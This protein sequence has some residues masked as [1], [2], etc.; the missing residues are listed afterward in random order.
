MILRQLLSDNSSLQT[1]LRG[2]LPDLKN[3]CRSLF[4]AERNT[5][6]ALPDY[7]PRNHKDMYFPG[8]SS[9]SAIISTT[10][11]SLTKEHLEVSG[12]AVHVRLETFT[13]WQE[14]LTW[15]PPLPL[16]AFAIQKQWRLS[17]LHRP[18]HLR[19]YIENY[20][21]PN[22]GFTALPTPFLPDLQALLRDEHGLSDIHIHLNGTTEVDHVWL[23]SLEN[24]FDYYQHQRNVFKSE[25]LALALA[26][27]QFQQLEPGLTP[28]MVYD[29][30]RLAGWL[31]HK[32]VGFLF[33]GDSLGKMELL[34]KLDLAA[35]PFSCREY[36]VIGK[37]PMHTVLG[38][39]GTSFNSM[40][41]ETIFYIAAFQELTCRKDPDSI[42]ASMFHCYLLLL[43]FFNKLVVQQATQCGFDQFQKIAVNGARSAS[44][45][46][47]ERRFRQIMGNSQNHLSFI[48]GRFSPKNSVAANRRLLSTIIDGFNS[49]KKSTAVEKESSNSIGLELRLVA[50]FIKQ[51]DKDGATEYKVRH[52]ELRLDLERRANALLV[53]RDSDHNIRKYVTGIDAA[54]NEMDTSPEVF[55]PLY[56]LLRRRGFRHFT[57]HAGEDYIH[58]VSGIRYLYEAI[59]FLDLRRGDRVGHATAVGI[60]PKLWLKR[61]GGCYVMG[62]QQWFDDLLFAHTQLINESHPVV[63]KLE[64][65]IHT[66]AWEIYQTTYPLAIYKMAWQLRGL[67]PLIA[68]DDVIAKQSDKL[69]FE[70]QS[71]WTRLEKAKKENEAAFEIFRKY[72][73]IG[74][75]KRG[76]EL[77]KIEDLFSEEILLKLQRSVLDE[78]HNKGVV[79]EAMPTSNVRISYYQNHSEHHIW[80]W[81]GVNRDARFTNE[82][83]PSI[84]IGS[85]DP[86]IF[87][88]NIVN[89]YAHIYQGLVSNYDQSQSSAADTL[90]RLEKNGRIYRFV[91]P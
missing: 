85:D 10:Y 2:E 45:K 24:P 63:G 78:L 68:F 51:P 91:N 60:D 15:M 71:E 14:L 3:V 88:T 65:K 70:D 89:E 47:Y 21:L 80:R 20:I 83:R 43:G 38:T 73:S 25:E 23:H 36:H 22:G 4:L 6:P 77:V 67:D 33:L 52:Q 66:L 50:H 59:K 41:L 62:K 55:A 1:Y 34:Q 48:E 69:R 84:C 49:V 75:Y 19:D 76:A 58:L 13:R 37:H 72:H 44:E 31:R 61:S 35:M 46:H 82:K 12:N 7:I 28:K 8:D 39:M 26:L 87:A 17:E 18:D 81:L 74:C 64:E 42:F 54:S 9:L 27:E 90:Q 5:N 56:R 29:R 53:A 32:M 79:I 57:F 40:Q 30:L 11:E 86:G 16:V